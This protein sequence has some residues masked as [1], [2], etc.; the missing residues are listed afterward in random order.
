[1]TTKYYKV[2]RKCLGQTSALGKGKG[3]R[4]TDLGRGWDE[5]YYEDEHG[6]HIEADEI[7]KTI[8]EA[9][10]KVVYKNS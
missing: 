10:E 9:N 2:T 4:W 1:M 5:S 8:T 3:Y 7:I 6:E